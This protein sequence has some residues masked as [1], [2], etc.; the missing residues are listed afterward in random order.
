MTNKEFRAFFK[1]EIE[2]TISASDKPALRQAW[3]DTI[4][5]MHRD[6]KLPDKALNWL[7]PRH[8]Y[9]NGDVMNHRGI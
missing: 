9:N 2:P 7:H 6:G 1:S 5:R 3:N 8:F 4:D